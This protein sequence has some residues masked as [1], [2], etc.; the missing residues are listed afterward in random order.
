M[1][2]SR[3][4]SSSATLPVVPVTAPDF[5]RWHVERPLAHCGEAGASG[6]VFGRPRRAD[7]M[8]GRSPLALSGLSVVSSWP[9]LASMSLCQSAAPLCG[10]LC[11]CFAASSRLA[12][13]RPGAA[14]QRRVTCSVPSAWSVAVPLSQHDFDYHGSYHSAITLPSISYPIPQGNCAP[15]FRHTVARLP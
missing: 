10:L 14:P 12:H 13:L 8:A 1:L 9:L 3:P 4:Q 2:Q 15:G 5:S 11:S 6:F 7:G